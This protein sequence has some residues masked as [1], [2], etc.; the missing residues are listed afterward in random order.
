[1]IGDFNIPLSVLDESNE[2]TNKKEN[3]ELNKL[4]E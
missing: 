1:M 2:K 4:L 3:M